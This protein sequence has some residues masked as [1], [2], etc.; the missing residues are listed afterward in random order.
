MA[1]AWNEIKDRALAFSREW[2]KAESEDA[3]AKPFWIEFFNV[4]GITS[5]R[6]GSFEQKVKK[7]GDRD[8]Y[9]DWLWKGNLLIEH[10]S[11]GRDLDRAY[12]QA[13]DYFPGLKEHELPRF[14]LV[15]DFARFRL[16][17]M[18]EGTQTEFLLKELYKNV[19]LFWF[20]AGY[21]PQK[22]S[23][24]SPVNAKAVQ[25]MAKL[26][27]QLKQIG[28]G[29]A[30][31]RDLEVYLV[32]LLFCLFAEDTGIFERTQF[33][34]FISQQ[35]REDG[36]DL[37]PQLAQ[38]FDVLNTPEHA[39]LKNLD[40]TL[41]R[42]PYVNGK[43]F[44][45]RL[46]FASFDRD[47]RAALLVCC[48]LDWSGISPAIFGSLFQNIMD[49]TPNARR[50]LGAHYT[51]E[52]NIL[53]LIRPLFLDELHA[54]FEK[55]RQTVKG[56]TQNLQAFH[57][58][59]AG[60][61]FLDPACGCGNFLV[62]AYRELRRLELE[63]L[64]TLHGGGQLVL[65]ISN[66]V[67]VNVD[68]FHGIEIEEFPVQ[69][70]QVA[71]WLTDHQM[72]AQVSEEFGQNFTRL[73]LTKSA[74]IVHGNAL[75]LDWNAVIP[76]EQ[77]HY[78]M[79]NPPF[80]GKTYLNDEQRA[81]VAAIFHDT[82]N[83]GLLD[84]VSCW[85]RKATDY[86][87]A[88]PAI[89]VAFVSTNSITQ[90]EQTGVLWP[91]LLRRGVHLH[92]AH[93]TFQW[94][95]EASGKAAVHCVIIGFGLQ[96]AAQKTIFEYAD[97]QGE[98][99]AVAAKNINPYLVDATDA[100]LENRTHPICNVPEMLYG[101][102]PVD[103]GNLLLSPEE[104]IELLSKEPQAEKWLQPLLGAEEFINGKTRWCLWLINIAPNE[105]RGMPE[106]M[107]RV[108]AVRIFRLKSTKAQTRQ[109]AATA[110]LFVENRQPESN[111]ILVPRVSSERR[112]FVP[113]GFF[114]SHT[115]S[116]D[117]NNMIPNATLYHFG[118]L[119]STMHNAWMR[120]VCGRLKSDYR[121][122]VGIVYNNFPWPEPS[123]TQ[124]R[125]IE[126]AARAVLNA[127][128]LFPNATLADLYDPLAMP[129]ELVR[130]HQRLD[131]AVDA[132]YGKKSFVSEAERV[133]FLFE[134]YQTI[135]S[136]LP[137]AA[138]RKPGKKTTKQPD[139]T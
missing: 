11:R 9:I 103:G 122:S 44:E 49:E 133:A 95:S 51:T 106:V 90:G 85:Y 88:H 48:A 28:Y 39:R 108:E 84:Y 5:R 58:K 77:C 64:R 80:I 112:L 12:Q 10:K 42:F 63:V 100:V 78:V 138:T 50:N 68:Q 113:I 76:A 46:P 72:N 86:I 117:L 131:R 62:I 105:L 15:S 123:D 61:R 97:I 111:Y 115:I 60:L 129:P 7:L 114:D 26:H 137:A 132:A 32:R 52:E 38:L 118:V 3:D 66:I 116:T 126:T 55:I 2:A 67:R 1:L 21:Q 13:I 70:A 30:K 16:Y 99:H 25:R 29:K 18:V 71:L 74:H 75:R 24:E 83:A 82:K 135:T 8:G 19:K 101:N 73:P 33:T 98:P 22:I 35:T 45:E 47:M 41:A 6:I 91:D 136:L 96:E 102:K 34:E 57:S 79:G 14:V 110:T 94:T 93:R 125:T 65:D 109:H 87:A 119:T 124:R 130:A 20:I 81:D 54:E 17:D 139:L 53:K 59:L 127:R 4:F 92:F 23:P 120:T 69:I 56:R 37:A 27:D 121:Y 134:R 40:D 43:L 31:P 36:S 104:K 89:R 128:A 107:K